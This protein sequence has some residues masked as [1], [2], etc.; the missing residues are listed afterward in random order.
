MRARRSPLLGWPSELTDGPVG[1]RPLRYGDSRAWADLRR[2][3]VAWLHEWEATPP[4]EAPEYPTTFRQMVRRYTAQ[5]QAD[6]AL[7]WAVTYEGRLAGQLNVSNVI[8]GSARMATVGY[9]VDG[10]LAG[11]GIIPTA[12]AMATDYCFFT[13]RLH[14]VEVNI[15]PENRPS[16]RVVE[17][18]GFRQEG[19]KPRLLHIDGGW[20]DHLSFALTVEDVP[21]GL[22]ARWHASQLSS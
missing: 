8:W 21:D 6:Q 9:W 17:K 5:G 11:H 18:L 22:L 20:R 4:P 15:R 13:A 2:R 14:R 1:L 7:P 16:L 10:D 3:N 12:L 19:L